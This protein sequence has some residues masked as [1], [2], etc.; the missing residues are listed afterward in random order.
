M[1]TPRDLALANF[2]HAQKAPTG[3][4]AITMYFYA[5]VHAVGHAASKKGVTFTDHPTRKAWVFSN[6][7]HVHTDY[8]ALEGFAHTAR[9]YPQKHPMPADA[10]DTAREYASNVLIAAGMAAAV[11]AAGMAPGGVVS[12]A[13]ARA[14]NPPD[15][16]GL[17]VCQA[18]VT[19]IRHDGLTL[20]RPRHPPRR[21]PGCPQR[22]WGGSAP[23]SGWVAS[24]ATR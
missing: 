13:V 3:E 2:T 20:C 22:A 21:S 7:S 12:V 24:G 18:V 8:T 19:Y 5:A 16:L 9:Y 6:L 10:V 14:K 23:S 11:H 1:K 15:P 4:W 17:A